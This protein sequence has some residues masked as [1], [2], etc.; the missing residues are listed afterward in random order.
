M[1]H[2]RVFAQV[3]GLVE[4]YRPRHIVI[5]A[6]GVGEGLWAL[7]DNAFP[8]IVIPV[9]FSAAKKS[10]IGWRF[11]SI[12]GTGRFKDHCHT[13]EVA[14]QYRHARSEILPGP[15]R[16]IRWGVPD[17]T[18]HQASGMPIHDDHLLADSLV[19]EIDFMTWSVATETVILQAPDPLEDMEGRF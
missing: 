13:P 6:T 3:K 1:N 14:L 9:K 16:H 18:R 17:G 2:I 19:A 4:A 12:I 7:L 15:A 8:G 11:L 5:D 10:E